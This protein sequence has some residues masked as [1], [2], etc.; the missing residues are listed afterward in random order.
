VT[1]HG[2]PM[3]GLVQFLLHDTF[4]NSRPVVPVVD[5]VAELPLEAWGAF[6]LG[7]LADGGKTKLELDL[8]KER[9]F[10]LLFRSR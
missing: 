1:D 8:S 2:L 4:P 9:S 10:P 3:N 5:G 7:A 6:T